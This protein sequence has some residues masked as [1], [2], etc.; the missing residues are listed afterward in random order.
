MA[1]LL[2]LPMSDLS[3]LNWVFIPFSPKNSNPKFPTNICSYWAKGGGNLQRFEQVHVLVYFEAN[4]IRIYASYKFTMWFSSCS[5]EFIP[6]KRQPEKP[7]SQRIY[8]MRICPS[9]DLNWVLISSRLRKNYWCNVI[10]S[11]RL[12]LGALSCKLLKN[13]DCRT[14]LL[15]KAK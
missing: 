1:Q 6:P 8:S 4:S 2:N 7:W 9:T 12:L 11:C 3:F 13:I 15:W 14:N 10:F 5:E